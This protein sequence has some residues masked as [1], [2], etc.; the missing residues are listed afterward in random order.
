MAPIVL[1]KTLAVTAILLFSSLIRADEIKLGGTGAALGTFHLLAAAYQE[2]NKSNTLRIFASMG[3]NGSMK[4][5]HS[6]AID[7]ALTARMPTEGETSVGA[8]ATLVGHTPFVFATHPSNKLSDVSLRFI[9][10][11]YAGNVT[12]WPN[13]KPLELV[14]RPAG[15]ADSETLRQISRDMRRAVT[16]SQER[17]GTLLRVTDQEAADSIEQIPGSLGPTTLALVLSEK[18]LVKILALDGVAPDVRS[19]VEGRYPLMK[20][21]YMVTG[22]SSSP[23]TLHFIQ[24]LKSDQ[25]RDILMR[26]GFWAH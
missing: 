5:L 17:K 26:A 8:R 16:A 18:R 23:A 21:I 1:L 14:L 19:L 15:D 12:E 9:A 4:A 20:S 13:G 24:F 6:G 22:S 25:A 2:K 11:A 7:I 3:S 10:D